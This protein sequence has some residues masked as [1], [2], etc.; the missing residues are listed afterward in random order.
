M[1]RA[2]RRQPREP[3]PSTKGMRSCVACRCKAPREALIRLV[4]DP[5]GRVLVDRYLKA[6]GRGA[7]LCY[8]RACLDQAVNRRAFGRAF[9]TAV[10]PVDVDALVAS[11]VAG[12]DA[13]LADAISIARRSNRALSG[14]DVLER[15]LG[16]VKLLLL[17]DDIAEASAA[18]LIRRAEALE[19]PHRRL[20][21]GRTELGT[22]LGKPERVA[23]GLSGARGAASVL[24][25]LDRRDR[26]VVAAPR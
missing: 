19:V 23:V 1:A 7:H 22:L 10:Q 14:N 11:V 8:D 4:C 25:E 21:M 9:K 24:E 5:E 18:R 12:I 15:G 26:I 17:S 6:P 16:R 20:P 3:R 13:R 2:S